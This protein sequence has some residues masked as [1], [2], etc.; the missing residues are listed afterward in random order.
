MK[1]LSVLKSVLEAP[2][3]QLLSDESVCEI[4]E[5]AFSMCFQMRLSELLRKY[6]EHVLVQMIHCIF[7][8]YCN[9]LCNIHHGL[10]ILM[11][12]LGD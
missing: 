11:W 12:M 10:Y 9:P 5:T 7:T 1:I 4:M 6:G 8:R 2:V 3:G